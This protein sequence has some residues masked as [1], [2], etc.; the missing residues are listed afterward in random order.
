MSFKRFSNI[1]AHR[2][3]QILKHQDSSV[4]ENGQVNQGVSGVDKLV[5][6]ED[7]VGRSLDVFRQSSEGVS[8]DNALMQQMRIENVSIIRILVNYLRYFLFFFLGGSLIF[9]RRFILYYF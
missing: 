9:F 4:Y 7:T 2:F 1:F 3:A 8:L 6:M 5:E